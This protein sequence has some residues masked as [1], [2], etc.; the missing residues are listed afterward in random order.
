MGAR[1]A[2]QRHF[3][4]GGNHCLIHRPPETPALG[5]GLVLARALR[6]KLFVTK[7]YKYL[8]YFKASV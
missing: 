6:D 5:A 2:A 7:Y 8:L 3:A 1:T 4:C